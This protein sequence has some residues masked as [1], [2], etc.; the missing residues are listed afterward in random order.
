VAPGRIVSLVKHAGTHARPLLEWG[1]ISHAGSSR[2][3]VNDVFAGVVV[4]QK[5]VLGAAGPGELFVQPPIAVL[6]DASHDPMIPNLP[7][8]HQ[9]PDR[10]IV[11]QAP[12][13]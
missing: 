11:E 4:A 10:S 1:A 3:G 9:A 7:K 2:T 5:V 12:C 6:E 8:D 13:P